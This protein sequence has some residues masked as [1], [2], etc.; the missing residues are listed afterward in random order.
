MIHTSVQSQ[1]FLFSY[2]PV[3]YQEYL[4][5]I[6]PDAGV[7]NDLSYT[8]KKAADMMGSPSRHTDTF[9]TVASFFANAEA[10]DQIA[11]DIKC[12]LKSKLRPSFIWLD[13]Y[14][15]NPASGCIYIKSKPVAYLRAIQQAIYPT[16]AISSAIE[17]SKKVNFVKEPHVVIA[18]TNRKKVAE[19]WQQFKDKKYENKFIVDSLY[20]LRKNVAEDTCELVAEIKL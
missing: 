10:E 4:L 2:T 6:N 3:I 15:C 8:Q 11:K 20:L 18:R 16:L 17:K 5:V 14:G 12:S 19:L 1:T 7:A 13:N 9:I